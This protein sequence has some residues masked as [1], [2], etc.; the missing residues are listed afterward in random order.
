MRTCMRSTLPAPAPPARPT[1]RAL[2][3]P[4]CR[5]LGQ[6]FLGG[7]GEPS[8]AAARLEGRLE[9][10]TPAL[11]RLP[12]LNGLYLGGHGL[13]GGLPP[14]WARTGGLLQRLQVLDL[15]ANALSGSIPPAWLDCPMSRL[16]PTAMDLEWR[17]RV[18][19]WPMQT[20]LLGR[21]AL[22]GGLP[23]TWPM[24]FR[25][26][27]VSPQGWLEPPAV[28]LLRSW[29][30]SGVGGRSLSAVG[31]LRAAAGRVGCS[32]T[33]A[34]P[35]PA[36]APPP[37]LLDLSSNQFHGP[38]PDGWFEWNAFPWASLVTVAGNP[39][40]GALPTLDALL[41]E[42]ALARVAEYLDER[43]IRGRSAPTR[44]NLVLDLSGCGIGGG[45]PPG[46]AR[47]PRIPMLRGLRLNG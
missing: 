34:L 19:R 3:A 23:P 5:H 28:P 45:L 4:P 42:E 11:E 43:N 30:G 17:G 32:C 15:Q 46:W 39:L 20:L 9:D 47:V 16:P 14:R 6:R 12:A 13:S 21:N 35:P 40:G 33:P 10:L 18:A 1:S 31:H 22:A 7:G 26:A 41:T 29:Q 24:C 25:Y 2:P 8:A 38:V 37:Q 44:P 27:V 36:L